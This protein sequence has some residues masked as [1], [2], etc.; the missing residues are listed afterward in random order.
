[1]KQIQM[2]MDRS[3]VIDNEFTPP[4]EIINA[5]EKHKDDYIPLTI[6]HDVRKPPVGRIWPTT[7]TVDDDGTYLLQAK[8]EVFEELDDLDSI[9]KGKRVVRIQAE[10]VETF[11]AI[12]NQTFEEDEDIAD[13][14]RELQHLGSGEVNQAYR[15]NSVDPISLLII[16]CG[17]FVLQGI[18]NGFFSKLG[19][20]L[21]E[22]LKLKLKN[23]YARKR[24][25]EKEQLLLF[26]LFITSSAGKTVEVN[27]VI[28]NPS[29]EDI[30]GFFNFV[31]AMLDTMLPQIPIDDLD[32][33]RVVFSYQFAELKVLYGL[34]SDSIP[35]MLYYREK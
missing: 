16:G 3:G 21:Y 17:V 14:Y 4:E 9:P 13:L 24:L 30:D 28:T 6:G 23:I 31:P 11:Q 25:K 35:V 20:D 15:E 5:L 32:L 2:V 33:C 7:V 12:G 8:G 29:C 19:E 1:M 26:K 18:S 27:I 34:R 22:A 10:E